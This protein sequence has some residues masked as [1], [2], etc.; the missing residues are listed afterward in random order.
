MID[1]KAELNPMRMILARREPVELMIELNNNSNKSQMISLEIFAG[2][3]LSFDKG[4][5]SSFQ[6]KKIIEFKAG[7]RLR[8]YYNIYPRPNT[9][10]SI[11]TIQV[12]LNEHFNNSFQ[13]VQSKKVKELALRVE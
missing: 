2:D 7:E 11:Q 1:L 9:N 13:Y 8:D 6:S 4:G 10:S 12:V 5:R 3:E